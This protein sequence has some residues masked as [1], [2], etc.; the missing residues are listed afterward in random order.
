[1]G[2]VLAAAFQ[3]GLPVTG[4]N[5]GVRGETSLQV[6]SRWRQETRPR[7]LPGADTRVVV[8]FGVNDTTAE[9]GRPRVGAEESCDAL[10]DML[11]RAETIGVPVLVVGPAPVDDVAQNRRI[12]ALS[13]SFGYVCARR[14]TPFVGVLEELSASSVWCEQVARDDG[15]HPAAEGYQALAQIVLADGWI[16]WLR[17][18]PGSDLR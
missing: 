14:G 16:D 12:E 5:L 15:A 2:R 8:S 18:A 3:A 7:L 6:A 11:E 9:G 4:Y 10:A 1:M 13:A 17:K